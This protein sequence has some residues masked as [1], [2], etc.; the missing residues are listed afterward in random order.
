V[1]EPLSSLYARIVPELA[2]KAKA[3][4]GNRAPVSTENAKTQPKWSPRFSWKGDVQP[5][6]RFWHTNR[7]TMAAILL[8][9]AIP[10]RRFSELLQ[11][12]AYR[13]HPSHSVKVP[14]RSYSVDGEEKC[15]TCGPRGLLA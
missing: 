3:I 4:S 14:F 2:D 1:A 10:H 9:A 6:S 11:W 8:C 7:G 15:R 5:V 12:R 13:P